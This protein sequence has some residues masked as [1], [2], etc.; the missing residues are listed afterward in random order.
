[1]LNRS[2]V[3]QSKKYLDVLSASKKRQLKSFERVQDDAEEIPG[4]V[5]DKEQLQSESEDFENPLK[6]IKPTPVEER[7]VVRPLS[8]TSSSPEGLDMPEDIFG[9][10][11]EMNEVEFDPFKTDRKTLKGK[12]PVNP[13]VPGKKSSSNQIQKRSQAV[14]KDKESE[15]VQVTE[16]IKKKADDTKKIVKSGQ[17][18]THTLE[19]EEDTEDEIFMR[20][21]RERRELEFIVPSVSNP[22]EQR[23]SKTN[24]E[25]MIRSPSVDPCAQT[26][27]E[28]S[29]AEK[30][31]SIEIIKETITRKPPQKPPQKPLQKQPQNGS[32]RK[33]KVAEEEARLLSDDSHHEV[34]WNW[35]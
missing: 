24:T 20:R 15:E 13:N 11:E 1:M 31:K 5:M 4:H 34:N 12:T 18:S 25:A 2:A 35:I 10:T 6:R 23:S 9:T 21:L 32:K 8:F 27:L 7:F 14:S 30:D 3:P 29:P 26:P 17:W 16:I 19:H 33:D 22:S 28:T